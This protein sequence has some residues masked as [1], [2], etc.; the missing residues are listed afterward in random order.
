MSFEMLKNSF[1]VPQKDFFAQ[2]HHFVNDDTKFLRDEPRLGRLESSFKHYTQKKGLIS[3][4]YDTFLSY[5]KHN[6]DGVMRKWERD[7]QKEYEEDSWSECI[8]TSQSTFLTKVQR[9]AIYTSQTTQNTCIS[10]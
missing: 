3:Y 4:F 1:G 9:D 8:T 10:K 7:F 2:A 6:I 5:D